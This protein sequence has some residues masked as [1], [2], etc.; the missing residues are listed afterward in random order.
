MPRISIFLRRFGQD[1]LFVDGEPAANTEA[2]VNAFQ[3][4]YDFTFT[5]EAYDPSF[6]QNWFA[7]F[8]QPRGHGG[9]RS[10]VRGAAR[11]TDPELNFGVA[12]VQSLILT[13]RLPITMWS[14]TGA[15]R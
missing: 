5:Y 11:L 9:C 1:D 7:D 12:L 14:T 4:I 3:M 10:M 6:L 15:G 13:I 8:Q 2:A